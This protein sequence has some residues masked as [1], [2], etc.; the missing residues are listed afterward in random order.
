MK[1]ALLHSAAR[2]IPVT[3]DTPAAAFRLAPFRSEPLAADGED[4]QPG[5]RSGGS[6]IVRFALTVVGAFS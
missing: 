1:G 2:R 4:G 6:T 5:Y 3:R